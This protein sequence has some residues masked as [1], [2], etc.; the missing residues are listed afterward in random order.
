MA[1][2]PVEVKEG[3][4]FAST[5]EPTLDFTVPTSPGFS[6]GATISLET[7]RTLILALQGKLEELDRR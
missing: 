2:R 4:P 7:A 1:Q 3:L 6:T 5:G